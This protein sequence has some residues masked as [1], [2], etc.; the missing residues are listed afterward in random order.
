MS[1]LAGNPQKQPSDEAK[2]TKRTF[3]FRFVW[4]QMQKN[5]FLRGN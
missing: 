3:F 1:L 2:A 4:M 5:V